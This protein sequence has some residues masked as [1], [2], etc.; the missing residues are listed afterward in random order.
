VTVYRPLGLALLTL[1]LLTACGD[2][3]PRDG[4]GVAS[5]QSG[6]APA[7]S[8]SPSSAAERPL[9]RTDTSDEEK[10]RLWNEYHRCLAD[11]GL[12]KERQDKAQAG[13]D[14]SAAAALASCAGKEPELV[15]QR[16]K[17]TDPQYADKLRDWVTCVRAAGIDAWEENGFMAFKS[18]PPADQMRKV[19]A[20]QDKAFGRG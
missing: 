4:G 11:Q 7:A 9:I 5:M 2:A 6:A 16:A 19:D 8:A 20:C 17:R 1:S 10:D 3:Q 12:T 15:W 13:A 18:L 14:P